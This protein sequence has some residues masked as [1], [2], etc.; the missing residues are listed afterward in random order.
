MRAETCFLFMMEILRLVGQA[1][2]YTSGIFLVLGLLAPYLP[3][4]A[5]WT[6]IWI[7]GR[8]QTSVLLILIFFIQ[9][10]I[11]GIPNLFAAGFLFAVFAG[12][13]WCISEIFP[14]FPFGPKEM[15]DAR[16]DGEEHRLS[17]LLFNVLEENEQYDRGLE[18]I[19]EADADIVFLSETNHAWA[20][21][22]E[23][24]K[25]KYPFMYLLP[26][27]DHN[28]LLFYSRVQ[29]DMVELKHVCQEHI[30]SLY[31]DL[32]LADDCPLRVYGI[33]PRPPRPEDDVEDLDDELI[34]VGKDAKKQ[35]CPVLVMGDL[36]EVGWSPAIRA[37]EDVSNLRDPKRGRGIFNTYGAKSPILRWPLD[38]IFASHHFRVV[39]IE[40]LK[41]CGSDHFP[42]KYTFAIS[43]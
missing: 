18:R 36:N 30:P 8:Q 26:L 33:H 29:I 20:D 3:V 28:G 1:L 42:I 19:L 16:P 6:R 15:K 2:L 35:E 5:W 43:T 10:G 25:E 17:I 22:L 34:I 41:A 27:E 40:R 23:P 24:L 7:Y 39:D 31:I 11:F 14:Y 37:F 13:V 12:F 9:L 38:H 32:R 21:A 4:K